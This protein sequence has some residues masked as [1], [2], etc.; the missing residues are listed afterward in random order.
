MEVEYGAIDE[1]EC[2]VDRELNA[3]LEAEV[4]SAAINYREARVERETET[5]SHMK[6]FFRNEAF[7]KRY[8]TALLKQ[9]LDVNQTS[10]LGQKL[11]I[12]MKW[13][14]W[15]EIRVKGCSQHQWGC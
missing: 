9:K 1:R 6:G 11:E 14:L 2:D 5:V 4:S 12:S 3:E 13:S 7:M 8:L 15:M 10:I